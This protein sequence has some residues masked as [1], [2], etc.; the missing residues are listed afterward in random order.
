MTSAIRVVAA[1]V[2]LASLGAA[3]TEEKAPRAIQVDRLAPDFT[4]KLMNGTQV[5]RDALRGQVVIINFWATWCVPCRTELPLLDN[6]Y[7]AARKH[8]LS[9][10]AITTEDSLPLYRL[11][12]L[13]AA[14]AIP[15][16][17]SIKGPYGAVT[18]VPYNIIIDRSGRVRY[19]AAGAFS[20]DELN[21]QVIPLLN[22]KAP[23]V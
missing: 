10:Y 23:A 11:K 20:L 4:L 15:S 5:T 2:A 18:A 19:A 7:R 12:P 8:G 22:E 21:E 13:F 1:M 9:V 6:Y 14:M 3:P 17:R 16:A